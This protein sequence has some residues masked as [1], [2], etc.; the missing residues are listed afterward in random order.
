MTKIKRLSLGS[1][2]QFRGAEFTS[3]IQERDRCEIVFDRGVFT[4]TD[5]KTGENVN[6]A[7]TNVKFWIVER[8]AQPTA[9]EATVSE[10][11]VEAPK[12][13]G[14]PAKSE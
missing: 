6:F 12:R 1:S 13:R 9:T 11:A 8:E 10:D 3:F 14:R 2:I 5:P 7:T 4:V